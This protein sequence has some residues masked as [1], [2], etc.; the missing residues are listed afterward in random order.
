MI[1]KALLS[2]PR[3]AEPWSLTSRKVWSIG[4]VILLSSCASAGTNVD[5]AKVATFE[6]GRTTI[7]QVEAALGPPNATT[8]LADGSQ[9]DVYS[10]VHAQARPETFIPIVGPLVGGADARSQTVSF[11]FGPDGVL[12]SGSSSRSQI[13]SGFG[14]SAQ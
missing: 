10:Y 11:V 2:M 8:T 7:Y 13:E 6:R 4:A 12:R 3:M 1:R 5:P 9:V 14:L